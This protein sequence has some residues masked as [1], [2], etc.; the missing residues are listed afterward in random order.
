LTITNSAGLKKKRSKYQL[1]IRPDDDVSSQYSTL[2]YYHDAFPSAT[3]KVIDQRC[4]LTNRKYG[5][6]SKVQKKTQF[7]AVADTTIDE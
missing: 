2:T 3:A 7:Q 4:A 6:N 5:Q 1:E